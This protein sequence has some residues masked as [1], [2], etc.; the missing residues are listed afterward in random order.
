ML[1]ASCFLQAQGNWPLD[2][3]TRKKCLHSS[4]ATW[5]QNTSSHL[6]PMTS[7]QANT[8]TEGYRIQCLYVLFNLSLSFT[9]SNKSC[10]LKNTI[11]NH[12]FVFGVSFVRLPTRT[13]KTMHRVIE[14][15]ARSGLSSQ[16]QISAFFWEIRL[17]N[18]A[19]L[20]YVKR[21]SIC[22]WN[23]DADNREDMTFLKRFPK[24]MRPRVSL[25]VIPI[26]DV[27]PGTKLIYWI[28]T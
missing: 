15:Q 6:E 23:T 19:V 1:C 24:T 10:W 7:T 14:T 22:P 16:D 20:S 26:W 18:S 11:L 13:W 17:G 21:K 12:T 27:R 9:H 25:R 3:G 5:S 4:S 8:A 28:W 2:K